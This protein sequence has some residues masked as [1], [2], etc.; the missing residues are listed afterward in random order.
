M[1][2][3][4]LTLQLL[5]NPCWREFSSILKT[6]ILPTILK[7]S[8]FYLI[9]LENHQHPKKNRLQISSLPHK[10]IHYF[11]PTHLRAFLNNRPQG[12]SFHA[13]A[14]PSGIHDPTPAITRRSGCGIVASTLDMVDP[15]GQ[16]GL[17]HIEIQGGK[18]DSREQRIAYLPSPLVKPAMPNG[19]PL[20][21]A[22]YSSVGLRRLSR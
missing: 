7:V 18:R 14:L 10:A 19:D 4:A 13:S 3:L 6:P 20:G 11:H 17:S 9:H 22:G 8:Y 16:S 1:P 15:S 21:L 2:I 12:P 5:S